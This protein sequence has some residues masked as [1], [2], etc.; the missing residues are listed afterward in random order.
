MDARHALEVSLAWATGILAVLMAAGMPAAYFLSG[1]QHDLG[2]F[3]AQSD[4]V[5]RAVN[6]KIAEVPDTWRLEEARFAALLQSVH[7]EWESAE[8]EMHFLRLLDGGG[9]TVASAGRDLPWPAVGFVRPVHDFGVEVGRLEVAQSFRQLSIRTAKVA[10][11]GLILGLIVFFPLRLIPL[12][13]LGRTAAAL[14]RERARAEVILNCV[15]EGVV[16]IDRNEII[17]YLNPAGARLLQW[18]RTEAL[19]LPLERVFHLK[20]GAC[21]NGGRV[22]DAT[23]LRPDGSELAVEYVVADVMEDEKA[24]GQVVAVRDVSER[25]KAAHALACKAAELERSNAELQRFAYIASH[26]LQ[27][28]LRTVTFYTQI[29]KKRYAPQLGTE[30]IE[31]VDFATDGARRMSMLIKDLLE[32]SRVQAQ[33][34]VRQPTVAE[35]VLATVMESMAR[36]IVENLAVVTHAP[37]P[38]VMANDKQLF[39]LFQNLI[40]NG[41]KFRGERPPEVHVA[42]RRDGDFWIFSV[43]DNGIGIAPEYFD[44]IFVI[45]QRLHTRDEYD[46]TGIGLAVCKRIVEAHGGRIWVESERGKGSTFFFS[47]PAALDSARPASEVRESLPA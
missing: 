17:G 28:P 31:F 1:Y 25:A 33:A 14:A 34:E 47:L 40:G 7:A 41:I 21:K 29:L 44:R 18:D 24:T 39:R 6:A 36:L 4:G 43:R 12:R 16:V 46:G 27:E 38:T 20:E 8:G 23:M 10:V 15:G 5:V 22:R 11:V 3:E 45:F 26:D 32:V 35:D 2:Q 19:G 9:V 37:L 30:G 13:V 42:A